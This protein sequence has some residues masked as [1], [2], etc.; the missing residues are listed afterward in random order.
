MVAFHQQRSQP[1]S[2]SRRPN[3]VI[4]VVGTVVLLVTP[5]ALHATGHLLVSSSDR[6]QTALPA[7]VASSAR[8]YAFYVNGEP[9]SYASLERNLDAFDVLLPQWVSLSDTDA[10]IKVD[11]DERA[12][13][14]VRHRRPQ[15]PILPVL[16]NYA[17]DDW[18]PAAVGRAVRSDPSRKRLV[19]ALS[20]VVAKNGFQGVCI[21]F[22]KVP[23]ATQHNLL[24]FLDRLHTAF[25]ARG[26]LVVA[27]VPFDDVSWKY[28]EYQAR[29]DSLVLLAYDENTPSDAPGPLAAEDWFDEILGRRMA[30]LQPAKTVVCI[31]NYGYDWVEGP[32]DADTM[33]FQ[34]V[35]RAT[36][37]LDHD[38]TFDR[39]TLNPHF[40]YVDDD[41]KTN[42]SVWFLDAV[43]AY[44]QMRAASKLG[45]ESFALWRLGSEDPSIWSVFGSRSTV[46]PLGGLRRIDPGYDV[47]SDGKGELLSISD[48]PQDG[49]R[50]LT[51]DPVSGLVTAER[52]GKVPSTY[53]LK[54][55]GDQPRLIALTFDD[56]PDPKWTPQILD[57]LEKKGVPATFFVVGQSAEANPDLVRR[58]AAD[59]HDVGNHGYSHSDLSYASASD[60]ETEL[61]A[62]QRI[63]QTLTG[64][65]TMLFRPRFHTDEE[66]QTPDEARVLLEAER[67][68]YVGVG[69]R[70]VPDDATAKT[71]DALVKQVVD[72]AESKDDD[73][74]GEIVILYDGRGDRS[75]TVA[76]LPKLIDTLRAKGFEFVAVSAL[77]DLKRDSAMPPV[78]ASVPTVGGW[79]P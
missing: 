61:D 4:T 21:D 79:A 24:V 37:D 53:A 70:I 65:G 6:A 52:Y 30:E 12:L 63:I 25:A 38:I 46:L 76:A 33:T 60:I 40:D 35:V 68:G 27:T 55:E 29:V 31:A 48:E 39:D 26:W 34:E 23:R 2:N 71:V 44:N 28:P 43:T 73:K 77:A 32:D 64:R 75:V 17:D 15:L 42:H 51:T 14:L 7:R 47:D 78:R 59:G 74:R 50:V 9:T 20:D 22:E 54:R 36:N 56:G 67:L 62:T 72:T 45:V 18:Q 5:V 11:V 13:E 19:D 3:R 41:D 16:R 1:G 58:I 57:I 10:P 69:A 66:P 49:A 8:T